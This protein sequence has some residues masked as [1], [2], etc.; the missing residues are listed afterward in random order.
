MGSLYGIVA[1][2][3]KPRIFHLSVHRHL[4]QVS[5]R[6]YYAIRS[7][8]GSQL[9]LCVLLETKNCLKTRLTPILRDAIARSPSGRWDAIGSHDQARPDQV[10]SQI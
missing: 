3:V 10:G 7:W 1:S 8:G 2:L 4:C 5:P 9:A 6:I